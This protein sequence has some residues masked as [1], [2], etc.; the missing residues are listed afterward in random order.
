MKKQVIPID[1]KTV[2]EYNK[3]LD[4]GEEYPYGC[5]YSTVESWT[6]CFGNG[7]EADIKVCCADDYSLFVDAVLFKDCGEAAL[8]GDPE[9]QLDGEYEFEFDDEI[10]VVEVVAA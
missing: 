10:Y 9:Y 3:Y 2:D 5:R 4:S 1:K 6:A 7:I 8:A